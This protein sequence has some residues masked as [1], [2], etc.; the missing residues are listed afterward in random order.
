MSEN[1]INDIKRTRAYFIYLIIVL[2]FVEILDTYATVIPGSFPSKI[3]EEFLG[4]Y[5]ENEQN[6]IM[7]LGASIASVGAY[8]IFFNQYLADRLGR[9][10]MLVITVLGMATASLLIILSTNYFQYVVFVFLLNFFQLSDIWLIYINEEAKKDKRAFYTNVLLIGGLSGAV[11]M[12]IL[13]SIYITDTV[14]NWRAMLWFPIILGFPLALIILLTFKETRQYEIM[15][16]EGKKK[17]KRTSFR[18]EIKELFQ[19][20]NK[21]AYQS[22]LIMSFIYGSSVIYLSLFE[23]Y[24][25]DVGTIS[26]SEVTLIFVW[27]ILA[28][29]IAYGLNGI[30]L[31]KIG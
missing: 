29:F 4:N 1:N 27:S 9:K 21:K 10:I 31:D 6:A 7:A 23:K 24:I 8:L 15:K 20:R 17:E 26:Q 22:I 12:V 16:K 3:A 5:S 18:Q 30:L 25:A 19:S 14:S 2:I 13:R 28:V 11:I